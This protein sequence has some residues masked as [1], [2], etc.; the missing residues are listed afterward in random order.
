MRAETVPARAELRSA[1]QFDLKSADLGI[2][3]IL[4]PVTLVGEQFRVLRATLDQLQKQRGIKVVLVTSAGPGEGKT[5]TACGLAGVIA[6]EP[7]KRVLLVDGDLRKPHA[8]K[9]VGLAGD[10]EAHRGFSDVLRGDLPAGDALLSAMDGGLFLLPAGKVPPNPSELLS[11]PNLEAGLKAVRDLFD[12]VVVD[13]PPVL[14]LS[15]AGIL[16]QA[17]DTVL[18]VVHAGVTPSKLVKEAIARI[19]REKVCGILLNRVRHFK[20]SHYYHYY[21]YYHRGRKK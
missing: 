15:D 14:P 5:F 1:I 9:Q 4:D 6:Q 11:S 20:S 12:W 21:H 18:F 2:K 7:G 10:P 13:S 19:G 8:G 16:A 17:C 3:S